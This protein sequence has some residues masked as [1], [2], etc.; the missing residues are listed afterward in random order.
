MRIGLVSDIHL[1]HKD[2]GLWSQKLVRLAD[3]KPD[4]LFIAGDIADSHS[5]ETALL[6]LES[7]L[8]I[9]VFF[10]LGNHDYFGGTF[11]DVQSRIRRLAK[12]STYLTW[13]QEA[14]VQRLTDD[15]AVIGHECWG[16]GQ[17]DCRMTEEYFSDF[18]KI[19]DFDTLSASESWQLKGLLAEKSAQALQKWARQAAR[20]FS[21]VLILTH[22]PPFPEACYRR[23]GYPSEVVWPFFCSVAAGSAIKDAASASP[24]TQFQVFSGHTHF[25]IEKN[26][27]PNLN[28]RVLG[29]YREQ[30]E[31]PILEV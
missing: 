22:A 3:A 15:V 9:P 1:S 11:D 20:E 6:S 2:A 12:K 29:A 30:E 19:R 26:I 28:V 18:R 23:E 8:S 7:A 4:A 17:G 25:P 5:V 21:R 24:D 13:L 14:G 16:D 27:L 31:L 10:V